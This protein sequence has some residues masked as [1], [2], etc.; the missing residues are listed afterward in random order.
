MKAGGDSLAAI[1]DLT[2]RSLRMTETVIVWAQKQNV[3]ISSAAPE[4]S[5]GGLDGPRMRLMSP[6]IVG[7]L[8]VSPLSVGATL[9]IA[10]WRVS[11]G[12]KFRDIFSFAHFFS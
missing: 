4:I 5:A 7:G 6:Q 3:D 9:R 8:K 2:S 1:A 11:T 10:R 12:V